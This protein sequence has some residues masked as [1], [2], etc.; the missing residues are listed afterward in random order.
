MREE[1][2]K[3]EPG[4]EDRKLS[5]IQTAKILKLTDCSQSGPREKAN[6][7][8]VQLLLLEPQRSKVRYSVTQKS[9]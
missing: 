8:T 5:P 1:L 7:V 9:S 2:L 4:I 6:C 3:K